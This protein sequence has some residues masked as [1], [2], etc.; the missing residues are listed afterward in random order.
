MPVKPQYEC[1]RG[2][3]HHNSSI[4]QF[5]IKTRNTLPRCQA[6]AQSWVPSFC[7]E[8]RASPQ[9]LLLT[10]FHPSLLHP[11]EPPC[12]PCLEISL[13]LEPP[14]P[15]FSWR[16]CSRFWCSGSS[17]KQKNHKPRGKN[18]QESNLCLSPFF[19][20]Y[21]QRSMQTWFLGIAR[22][23][24]AWTIVLPSFGRNFRGSGVIT[25]WLCTY[26]RCHVWHPGGWL[27]SS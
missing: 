23:L 19:T 20:T 5:S 13:G 8:L 6:S 12:P 10:P 15:A 16:D 1:G 3:S 24:P 21:P 4:L 27:H 26:F 18:L 25:Q 7:T 11:S 9:F 14:P 22:W 2:H 17:S